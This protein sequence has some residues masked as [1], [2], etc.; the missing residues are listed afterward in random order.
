MIHVSREKPSVVDR[1]KLKAYAVSQRL[2]MWTDLGESREPFMAIIKN[3][4]EANPVIVQMIEV[5]DTNNFETRKECGYVARFE[6]KIIGDMGDSIVDFLVKVAD[7][8]VLLKLPADVQYRNKKLRDTLNKGNEG[9][10][11]EQKR[12]TPEEEAKLQKKRERRE[13]KKMSPKIKMVKG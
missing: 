1:L 4:V 3:F 5:A 6:F 2:T 8:F 12:L 13:G 7:E 10:K 9:K 11:G